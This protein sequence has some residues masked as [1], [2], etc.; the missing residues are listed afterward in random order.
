MASITVIDAN[1]AYGFTAAAGGETVN[2]SGAS[3]AL[4][5]FGGSDSEAII[6]GS[7]ADTLVGGTGSDTLVGGAGANIFVIGAEAGNANVH[8]FI[9]DFTANDAIFLGGSGTAGSLLANATIGSGGV[10]ITLSNGALV[11]FTNLSN[12][13]SLNGKIQVD[14][15]DPVSASAPPRNFYRSRYPGRRRIRRAFSYRCRRH[16]SGRS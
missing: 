10:T 14:G 12:P 11:T 5:V 2:G 8:Y 1:G 16:P 7:G 3:G 9:D 15:G 4:F 13:S 6:G